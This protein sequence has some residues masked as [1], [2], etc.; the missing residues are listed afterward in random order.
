MSIYYKREED[1]LGGHIKCK[2]SCA[3][4]ETQHASVKDRLITGGMG[5]AG[6]VLLILS[7]IMIGGELFDSYRMTPLFI[8]ILLFAV[9]LFS[10][11]NSRVAE[12]IIGFS[13]AVVILYVIIVRD[14]G[15]SYICVKGSTNLIYEY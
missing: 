5:A 2:K 9:S 4:I 11:I 12:L 15:L 10:I 1:I 7:G 6:S 3:D 8:I 14:S 13:A